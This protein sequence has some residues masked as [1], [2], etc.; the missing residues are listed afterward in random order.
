MS[1]HG[2]QCPEARTPALSKCAGQA[3]ALET[4]VAPGVPDGPLRATRAPFRGGSSSLLRQ[5]PR[6]WVMGLVHSNVVRFQGHLEVKGTPRVGLLTLKG[7]IPLAGCANV[8]LSRP[9][10]TSMDQ[11][12]RVFAAGVVARGSCESARTRAPGDQALLSVV[13]N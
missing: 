12:S 8:F 9:C 13:G 3:C 6:C 11:T 10:I 1:H 5:K 2:F 4:G 7:S